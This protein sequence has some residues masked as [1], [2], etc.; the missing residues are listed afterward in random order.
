MIIERNIHMTPIVES[1]TTSRWIP[2][3][4]TKR[5]TGLTAGRTIN[6]TIR[7]TATARIATIAFEYTLIQITYTPGVQIDG[8]SIAAH[9]DLSSDINRGKRASRELTPSIIDLAK[10]I[11]NRDVIEEARPAARDP[12]RHGDRDLFQVRHRVG[13][14]WLAH[15]HE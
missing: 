9:I 5:R 2:I 12:I 15:V 13:Y 1:L 4:F 11:Q 10:L 8:H 6:Q 14:V 3:K 7:T